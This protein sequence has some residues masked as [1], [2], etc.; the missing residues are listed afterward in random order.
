MMKKGRLFKLEANA[1]FKAENIDDAFKKLS[2][3][4]R[5]LSKYGLAK[6]NLICGGII[7]IH[8]YKI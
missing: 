6:S 2:I 3:H 5:K 1:E 7:E 8:P 4:F